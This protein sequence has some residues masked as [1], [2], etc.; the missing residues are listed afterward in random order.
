MSDWPTLS[1]LLDEI[2]DDIKAELAN[3]PEV[4]DIDP[5]SF[6][7]KNLPIQARRWHR[8]TDIVAVVVDLKG[9]TRLSTGK[10]HAANTASVYEAATD[11]A[12]RVF[13]QF[14][15]DFIQ[16][17]G[18]GVLAIF[19]GDRR[20]E[21]ALC[22][23]IT[24][25]T[26]GLTLGQRIANKWPTIETGYKV[27]I[28]S[29]RVLVKRIGTPRNPAEQEPVWA[30]KPVNFATKAAQHANLGEL[31]VTASVW[32]EIEKNDYLVTSCGHGDGKIT[33]P[34][35]LWTDVSID[36]IAD[37]V[38]SKGQKLKS[39]WCGW[40]GDEFCQKILEGET[41]REEAEDV[42]LEHATKARQ[43]L[44]AQFEEL[45]EMKK[46]QKRRWPR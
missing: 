3:K 41:T 43:F 33:E 16:I 45:I 10:E 4:K 38:Q 42:T 11:N 23:G 40:H 5:E 6:D 2:A 36:T 39:A 13:N 20:Y 34:T 17:Q 29:G 46:K 30:G 22:A 15:A 18:D 32:A 24:V 9:S 25:K 14:K 28:S 19:W 21:R 31:I 1:D 26:F 27:G 7:V 12:V 37:E 35:A 44:G 8:L